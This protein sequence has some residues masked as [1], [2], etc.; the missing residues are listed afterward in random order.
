MA[1]TVSVIVPNSV[2]AKF[3]K[4]AKE[5]FPNEMFAFL[6]GSVK[7]GV[8]N[9]TDIFF[10]TDVERYCRSNAVLVQAS[11]YKEVKKY[12]KIHSLKL[13]CDY[14]SHPY[15]KAE[16]SKGK[17][18]TAPSEQDWDSTKPCDIMAICL[19]TECRDGRLRART[20]F[21]GPLPQVKVKQPK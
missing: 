20:K 7:E 2:F 10:P 5:S 3:H 8:Y 4:R 19:V 14:H 9:I 16:M 12:C 15:D 17:P 6:L 18:D 21:W 1:N 13:I 11:W